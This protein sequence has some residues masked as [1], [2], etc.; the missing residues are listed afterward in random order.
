MWSSST[1]TSFYNKPI[2][3]VCLQAAA[4]MNYSSVHKSRDEPTNGEAMAHVEE[5]LIVES[6]PSQNNFK[7]G[8]LVS[9]ALLISEHE[10]TIHEGVE[11]GLQ[12]QGTRDRSVAS[13]GTD[14]DLPSSSVYSDDKSGARNCP[15]QPHYIGT[16]GDEQYGH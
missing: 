11:E 10:P 12:Q 13:G 8:T 2:V 6:P 16:S 4:T 14:T 7:M 15:L 9:S 3:S 5:G 1:S